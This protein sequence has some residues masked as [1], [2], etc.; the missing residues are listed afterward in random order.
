MIKDN[1]TFAIVKLRL[2]QC[3]EKGLNFD[4]K[5]FNCICTVNKIVFLVYT[6]FIVKLLKCSLFCKIK[7]ISEDIYIFI[8]LYNYLV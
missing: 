8:L 3:K 2:K 7:V 6:D 5:N 4:F 1:R